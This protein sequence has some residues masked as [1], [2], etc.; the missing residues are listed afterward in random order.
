MAIWEEKARKERERRDAELAKV[1]PPLS[2]AKEKLPLNS[3]DLPQ[4][5]LT[6]REYEI[7]QNNNV[8]T[9]LHKLQTWELSAEEVTRAF[10]RRAAIAQYAT[11]CLTDLM[12]DEAIER[13]KHLDSLSKPLGPLHGLPISLKEHQG[14]HI[15][16]KSTNVSYVSWIGSESPHSPLNEILWNAGCVFYAR[17][18]Q[19]QTLQCVETNNN[20]Y[21]RTVNPWNRNLSPGGSSGGEG[22]LIAMRGSLLGIGGDIGGSVRVPAANCG[23]YGFKPTAKRLGVSGMKAAMGG[24]EGILA[25]FGPLSTDREALELFVKTVL[26]AKPWRIDASLDAKLW[27]PVTLEGKLKVAVMWDDGVVKP[28]PPVIRALREVS[29]ACE[30]ASMNV[31]HWKPLQHDRAWDIYVSLLYPDGGAAARAPIDDSD[32]PMLPLTK[33][34]SCDQPAAKVRTIHEYWDL[35]ME[36][37]GYRNAY[38]VHWNNTSR[39]DSQE[40]DVILCPAGPNAAPLHDTSK[41]WPY[42]SHWNLLD[43]PAV[44]FPVTFVDPVEDVKETDFKPMNDQDVRNHDLYEPEKFIGAP[45]SLQLVGRRGMDEKVM[46]A[47]KEIERAMG[48]T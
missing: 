46:A 22:A 27:E 42:T 29:E 2:F 13:A 11:N 24:G 43:C 14:M 47:L 45:V 8:A 37:E 5:L 6:P 38:A 35:I 19:P 44:A 41:Y 1:E 7:T 12:W 16:K 18:N 23:I 15:Y 30:K 31:V 33:W 25:T 40:V 36:R 3:Q 4:Q 34:L 28:H 20:I 10:L 26:D 48:R 9:L 39:D 17:T 32:E 21:G